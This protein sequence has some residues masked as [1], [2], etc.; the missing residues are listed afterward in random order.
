MA[1][2]CAGVPAGGAATSALRRMP[3]SGG[4][5]GS[6]SG[7]RRGDGGGRCLGRDLGT[8][9]LDRARAAELAAIPQRLGK[10]LRLVAQIAERHGRNL[11]AGE[12][13]PGRSLLRIRPG[14]ELAIGPLAARTDGQRRERVRV[15]PLGQGEHEVVRVAALGRHRG[16]NGA[17]GDRCGIDKGAVGPDRAG[18]QRFER[19]IALEGAGRQPG[20]QRD[21]GLDARIGAVE[22]RRRAPPAGPAEEEVR[23]DLGDLLEAGAPIGN[24]PVGVIMRRMAHR[25]VDRAGQCGAGDVARAL[26][27]GGGGR[28][29]QHR[30]IAGERELAAGRALRALEHDAA[31]RLGKGRV[32]CAVDDHLRDRPLAHRIVAGLVID[33]CS[34]AIDGAGPAILGTVDIERPGR[35]IGQGREGNGRIPGARVVRRHDLKLDRLHFR[36]FGLRHHSVRY[37]HRRG[38]VH[39]R[40]RGMR[41]QPQGQRD[42]RKHEEAEQCHQHWRHADG[43]CSGGGKGRDGRHGVAAHNAEVAKLEPLRRRNAAMPGSVRPTRA[44]FGQKPV[45]SH[46]SQ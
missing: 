2:S 37:L 36:Q 19:G 21:I 32:A 23:A 27:G 13:Q 31:D 39:H 10:A 29:A 5:N 35:R 1:L 42:R 17:L 7:D 41:D 16:G 14:H 34:E 8:H 12:R 4:G 30:A 22:R 44:Q 24:N 3:A 38:L 11:G 46:M 43:E 40:A 26:P 9:A 20:H 45:A 25:L 15:D 18:Q 33:C 6:G 28:I